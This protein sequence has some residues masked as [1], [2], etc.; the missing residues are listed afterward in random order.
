[1]V[2][3]EEVSVLQVWVGPDSRGPPIRSP[4]SFFH[5]EYLH[6]TLIPG[7]STRVLSVEFSLGGL[8]L[9]DP[10]WGNPESA[11]QLSDPRP[12]ATHSWPKARSNPEFHPGRDGGRGKCKTQRNLVAGS[13][14]SDAKA[15]Q[16]KDAVCLLPNSIGR[17]FP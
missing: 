5:S 14:R 9:L 2:Q 15:P 13:L 16:S 7:G 17:G 11:S 8:E 1:M 12:E 6:H 4:S 10:S 3:T